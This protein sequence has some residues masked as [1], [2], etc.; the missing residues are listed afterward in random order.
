M[1]AHEL[2]EALRKMPPE[3]PVLCDEEEV[4]FVV[5]EEQ[6]YLNESLTDYVNYPAV[7]LR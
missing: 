6:Y 7:V 4:E 5:L 2:I 3:A 1:T